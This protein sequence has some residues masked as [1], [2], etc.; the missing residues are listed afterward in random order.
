M[1][2]MSRNAGW[3]SR[4]LVRLVLKGGGGWEAEFVKEW[5][6]GHL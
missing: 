5:G 4:T 6:P 3:A 1:F 2:S